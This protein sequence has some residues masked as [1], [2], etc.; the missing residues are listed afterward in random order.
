VVL[1]RVGTFRVVATTRWDSPVRAWVVGAAAAG[2]VDTTMASDWSFEG[3]SPRAPAGRWP[4]FGDSG[5]VAAEDS[6]GAA[7]VVPRGV[8]GFGVSFLSG[9]GEADL[10]RRREA[11]RGFRASN[12]ALAPTFG[13]V[14]GGEPGFWDPVPS[15]DTTTTEVILGS[16]SF[17]EL[18]SF[19]E[20]SS[21][22]ELSFLEL[23]SFLASWAF[24]VAGEEVERFLLLVEET[25][26]PG[27]E[28]GALGA[29]GVVPELF[30][31]FS[32]FEG[33]SSLS[34]WLS[35]LCF[36][37]FLPEDEVSSF[38]SLVSFSGFLDFSS[39]SWELA[40]RSLL[41]SLLVDFLRFERLSLLATSGGKVMLMDAT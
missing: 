11:W 25:T 31:C 6:A 8:L 2:R 36:D 28:G 34:F 1:A 29:F 13:E 32:D 10:L 12:F 5:E 7:E 26:R 24:G 19:L 18:S 17:L 16:S 22:L 38:F 20:V 41:F 40:W 37:L 4:V 3:I 39:V 23:S 15:P 35:L 30:L 27:E 9:S 14:T 33:V 21:F